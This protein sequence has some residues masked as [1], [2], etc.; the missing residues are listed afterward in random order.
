MYPYT[1][2]FN[3]NLVMWV[4][5]FSRSLHPWFDWAALPHSKEVYIDRLVACTTPT[6]W[7]SK[8]PGNIF[9]LSTSKFYA[10]I[11][12]KYGAWWWLNMVWLQVKHLSKLSA[13]C[14][15]LEF[16]SSLVAVMSAVWTDYPQTPFRLFVR[17]MHIWSV[18]LGVWFSLRVRE[19]P[20]SNPGQ[21]QFFSFISLSKLGQ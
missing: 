19:V 2:I 10:S 9:L 12:K 16:Y 6:I 20:G 18:G 17:E 15:F 7:F 4:L 5:L 8:V 1:N 3:S 11:P 13:A 21:T 14:I